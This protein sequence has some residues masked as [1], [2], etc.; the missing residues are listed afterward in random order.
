MVRAEQIRK[1]ALVLLSMQRHSWEQGTAMQAFLE[2]GEMEVV[3]AMSR[4]AVYRRLEDG[5][6][7]TI[8]VTDGVTD[9]CSV[10]E[11]LLAACR[12]CGE[13]L[14]KEGL[15]ALLSWTLERAPRNEEGIL[16]HLTTSRQFWVDSMYMLPPFLAAAGY[17]EEAFKQ[18]E[19]YWNALYDDKAALM[20]HMWDDEKK[21]YVRAAHWGS[22]NGWAMAGL[23]R[24]L[25]LIPDRGY[26]RQREIIKKRVKK[27]L[28]GVLFYVREDG[29]FHDV[30]DDPSSFVETNL[31]Q[32]TSYTIYRGLKEG[33]LSG[34]GFKEQ[35]DRLRRAAEGQMDPQGFVRG[36]CGAPGFD[37]PG[38]SPEGQAFFLLME[39]AYMDYEKG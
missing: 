13:P 31:S 12:S 8:G 2:M 24:L 35:A 9:P 17:Y 4:E 21:E 16:Y 23:A 25:H 3:T 10:G 1:G 7:A 38:F 33:W 37:R 19:G 26:E 39:Q 29:L 15:S 34:P 14:L 28:D 32:M 11:A 6:A 20:C 5:R 18:A 22:G 36:V 27:L 30:V